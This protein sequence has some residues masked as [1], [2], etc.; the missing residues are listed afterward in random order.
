MLALREIRDCVRALPW[1]FPDR[2]GGTGRVLCSSPT[3]SS[4]AMP[5]SMAQLCSMRAVTLLICDMDR[6]LDGFR[7]LV[8]AS[9]RRIVGAAAH[10]RALA[11]ARDVKMI[12]QVYIGIRCAP[13]I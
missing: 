7:G 6:V 1:Y 3:S 12:F 8:G 4:M 11:R 5:R 10:T 13:R 2:I 9:G